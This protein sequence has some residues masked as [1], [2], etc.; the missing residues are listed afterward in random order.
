LALAARS[1]A[2]ALLVDLTGDVPHAL[3]LPDPQGPGLTDWS[4]AGASAPPD[5]LDRLAIPVGR[6]L[7]VLPRGTGRLVA[8]R[9]Q[10]LASLLAHD[11]RPVVVD[12][13]RV[14]LGSGPS[15]TREVVAAAARSLLVVRPCQLALR[16]AQAVSVRA[17]GVIVVRE[18][19]R[20]ITDADVERV[21]GVPVVAALAVDPAV[22]RVV[23]AGLLASRLPR[24]FAAAVAALAT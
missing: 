5:A 11:E 18:P 6:D 23:D 22:A 2:G 15:V 20:A 7:E 4:A 10:V 16:R 9:G 1:D 8:E 21:L 3:G 17:S 19:A 24:S 14:D 12:A 13:G